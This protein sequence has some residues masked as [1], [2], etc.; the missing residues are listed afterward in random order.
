MLYAPAMLLRTAPRNRRP[1]FFS[2]SCT[3]AVLAPELLFIR[4]TRQ[5]FTIPAWLLVWLKTIGD[6]AAAEFSA[7]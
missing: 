5:T 3:N 1:Q 4:G 7:A 2:L 6:E